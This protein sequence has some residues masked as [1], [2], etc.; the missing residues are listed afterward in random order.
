MSR[1]ILNP[2]RPS[3]ASTSYVDFDSNSDALDNL[4]LDAGDL[5]F[6]QDPDNSP[7]TDNLEGLAQIISCSISCMPNV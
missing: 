1:V 5:F 4:D 2:S 7:D 3:S 6:S